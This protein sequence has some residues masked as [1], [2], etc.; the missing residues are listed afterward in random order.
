MAENEE[1]TVESS[2]SSASFVP[3]AIKFGFKDFETVGSSQRA[4]CSFCKVRT[5]ITDRNGVT[6]N[7]LKHLQRMHP[8]K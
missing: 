6:S 1:N 2:C 8:D 5:M 3:K 4:V 7:F